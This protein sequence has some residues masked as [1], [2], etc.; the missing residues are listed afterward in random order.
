MCY[1]LAHS[2]YLRLTIGLNPP[3]SPNQRICSEAI[4]SVNKNG[5]GSALLLVPMI[6][7]GR[8]GA[9]SPH[10]PIVFSPN[11]KGCEKYYLSHLPI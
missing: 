7:K 5:T 2:K 9:P 10:V 8:L 11:K 4:L 1:S 3:D 6:K